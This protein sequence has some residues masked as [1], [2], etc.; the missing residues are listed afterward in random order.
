VAAR[1]ADPGDPPCRA[2]PRDR[3][4]ADRYGL[5]L[6]GEA[7]GTAPDPLRP[8]IPLVGIFGMLAAEAQP[9]VMYTLVEAPAV[10]C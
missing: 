3:F 1:T 4:A 7:D 2:L 5:L 10:C 8:D 6:T 9:A